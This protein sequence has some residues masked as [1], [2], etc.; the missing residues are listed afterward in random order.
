MPPTKPKVKSKVKSKARAARG[1]GRPPKPS[2]KKYLSQVRISITDQMREELDAVSEAHD[3]IT[4]DIIRR[5][6]SYLLSLTYEEQ[7]SVLFRNR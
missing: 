3:T 4:S 7:I 6:L 5:L 2:D 1:P